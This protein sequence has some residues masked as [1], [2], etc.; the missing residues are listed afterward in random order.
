MA[1]KEL[2]YTVTDQGRDFGKVYVLTEMSARAGHAWATRALF[3]AMNGG[4]DIPDNILSAG[5]AGLATVLLRSLGKMSVYVAQPL[6]DELLDCVK[7]M[8]DPSKPNVVRA[9]ID[10]DTEEVKTIF[11]LQ[12]EVLSLHMDF[13]TSAAQS[14]S[15]LTT[16]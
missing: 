13:F 16:A 3:G 10:D 6:L 4:V 7:V 2:K 1:R 12:K 9:L 5:F 8:P 11:M 14:T 15:E